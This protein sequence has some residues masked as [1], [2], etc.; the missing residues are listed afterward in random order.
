MEQTGS[1]HWPPLPTQEVPTHPEQPANEAH[2]HRSSTNAREGAQ[3]C[4]NDRATESS[5]P[6][7]RSTPSVRNNNTNINPA[8]KR[9]NFRGRNGTN[10]IGQMVTFDTN[11]DNTHRKDAS[12]SESISDAVAQQ[13]SAS[14]DEADFGQYVKRR[15]KRYYVGGFKP[16]ITDS[17]LAKYINDQGLKVTNI[18]IMRKRRFNNV[19]IRI[20]LEDD[21]QADNILKEDFWPSGIVCRPWKPP[22]RQPQQG[23]GYKSGTSH[24]YSDGTRGRS[25]TEHQDD[26]YRSDSRAWNSHERAYDTQRHTDHRTRPSVQERDLDYYNVD[27]QNRFDRLENDIYYQRNSKSERKAPTR[28]S[29]WLLSE[30][31]GLEKGG[32][33]QNH[34]TTMPSAGN[35]HLPTAV[36]YITGAGNLHLPTAV[37]YITGAGNLH[38]PTAVVYIT[39][40][41]NLHLPT[42]VVY[43]TVAGNLHLPT[44][45]VYITVAGNLH[46]PTAVVYITVAGN[47]HLPTAVVYITVAGNLHLP[48]AVNLQKQFKLI[49]DME[50]TGSADSV[51][52]GTKMEEQKERSAQRQKELEE[53]LELEKRK[54]KLHEPLLKRRRVEQAELELERKFVNNAQE[55][56]DA[57]VSS[58]KTKMEEQKERSAQR[59]KE[60]EEELELERK[61]VNNAQ[62]A[63]DATVS[64]SKTKMEEQKERSAQRQKEL[65]EE[66]ELEK[67]KYSNAQEPL[68]ATELHEPLLKRRRVEQAEL[69]LERKFVNNAQ[70]ALDATVSSSKT[71]MEEQKERSAQRQKKLEEE[72]ELEKRKYSN[73]QEALDATE[74]HEP[75]LKRRRVEQ[76]RLR[77]TSILYQETSYH[78][79]GEMESNNKTQLQK[80][81]AEGECTW[82]LVIKALNDATWKM[83]YKRSYGIAEVA[84]WKMLYG[85]SYDNAE[86]ARWKMLY[87]KS[88]DNAEDVRWKMLYGRSYGIEEDER[89]KMLYERSY[90]I[91]GDAS[92]KIMYDRSYGIAEDAMWKMLYERS[93][94]MTVDARWKMLYERLYGN[95]GDAM[96]KMLYERSYD[97][98]EDAR[99]TMRQHFAEIVDL[100]KEGIEIVN[101]EKEGIEIIRGLE[102]EKL[103][104]NYRLSR[105]RRVVENAFGILTAR[106]RVLLTTMQQTPEIAATIV[107]SCVCLHN[108]MR[109][110]YP[111]LQQAQLDQED[112]QHNLVPG[113]WRTNEMLTAIQQVRGHNRDATDAKQQREYLSKY[114]NSAAGSSE[115]SSGCEETGIPAVTMLAV[116]MSSGKELELERKILDNA[117]EALDATELHEPLLKRR[118]A[119]QAIYIV[120]MLIPIAGEK[121]VI[122][123]AVTDLP[124]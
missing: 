97:T 121:V 119:E 39:G 98:A 76:A 2:Q 10:Y 55:A 29:I 43:I 69:E 31:C 106:F 46:L 17:R 40:A 67:R 49:K 59:Q 123:A 74:L 57:T 62:E 110:R 61:F 101:L 23:P 54:Y 96:W 80:E 81:R 36:V 95:A 120:A 53:E 42:A 5:E 85:R 65:E 37:V 19:V 35:L 34:I 82:F 75:L 30:F 89:W 38:L 90:G 63:L 70:E 6:E 93:Y 32:S 14:N 86:D 7:T 18:L 116:K 16:S 87:K 105:G 45:V 79:A 12:I 24:R 113:A 111:G 50:K 44:A 99:E 3:S 73:A 66:L 52:F 56:L 94:G 26:G 84:R 72:L 77:T 21:G 124:E 91:A 118:R 115:P 1:M 58:S 64:S 107:E 104:T 71:K 51:S 48:T 27:V 114:F 83:L 109:I 41:G 88:Y 100:E 13:P 33:L 108:L 9:M 103:I 92:W 8:S 28:T 60:L 78:S 47:L 122:N 15:P 22:S 4:A 112:D 25:S 102:R 117:Q 20:N 68:D 11:N